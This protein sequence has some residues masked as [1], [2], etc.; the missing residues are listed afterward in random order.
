MNFCISPGLLALATLAGALGVQPAAAVEP[1]TARPYPV[2]LRELRYEDPTRQTWTGNRPRPLVGA[3]WYPGQP[4]TTEVDW[5]VAIFHAGRNA[6]GAAPAATPAR[7]PLVLLSH[8]T[9]GA[10]AGLAWLGESL[11]AQG[12]LVAAVNHHGNTAAEDAPVLQG[13]A[14]WWDRPRDLSVVLDRLLADREWGPRIDTQRIGVAGFSLGGYAALASVGARLSARQ[15]DAHCATQAQSPLCR[16]PPEAKG[17]LADLQ[18]LA[19]SDARFRAALAGMDGDYRDPRIRAAFVMAP[20]FG[21]M[22]TRESLAAVNTPVH[23]VVG[24]AD[25]QAT[26]DDNARA[27]AK[28]IPRAELDVISKA[29]HYVF[30]PQCNWRGMAFVS[31][32]C[33]DP[34]GVKRQA[35]HAHVAAQA[36]T[37][38]GRTLAPGPSAR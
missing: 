29:G 31:E 1:V 8:G 30:L 19:A 32:I 15:R 38:F 11:A 9:G 2:G 37:F 10:A 24:A 17:T 18:K 21:P 4:G 14:I 22:L 28:A 26:P 16:L 34:P 13:F 6:Q 35:V 33:A 5:D 25:E 7:L 36:I 23:I 12:Y 3:L 20:V 27:I